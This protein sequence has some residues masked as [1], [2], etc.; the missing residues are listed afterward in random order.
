MERNIKAEEK[1]RLFLEKGYI[2]NSDGSV[3]SNTGNNVKGNNGNGYI[4]LCTEIDGKNIS[5]YGHHLVFY[6]TYRYVP[7]QINH[8]NH[9]RND[10]RIDNLEYSNAHH[11]CQ[12]KKIKGKCYSF[13][14]EK[15]SWRII[16]EFMNKYYFICY[17]KDEEEAKRLGEELRS[18]KTQEEILD[19]KQK[20]STR[21]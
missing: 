13:S 1:C 7:Q 4:R 3:T 16:R 11:N 21:S 8:K 5:V 20:N 17:V 12:N 15:Q 2:V 18:L 14:K 6:N 9:I 10:N 19:F